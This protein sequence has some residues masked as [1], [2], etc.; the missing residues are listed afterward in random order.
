MRVMRSDLFPVCGAGLAVRILLL[1]LALAAT[2]SSLPLVTFPPRTARG[3][4]SG[5][6]GAL[7]M[8][9]LAGDLGIGREAGGGRDT[10]CSLVLFEA[11]ESVGD[12]R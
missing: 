10:A 4:P 5:A 2:G 9:P 7:F 1:G 11:L 6:K 8:L 3:L 12:G